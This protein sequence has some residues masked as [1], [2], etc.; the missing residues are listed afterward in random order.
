MFSIRKVV[1]TV[2]TSSHRRPLRS[3]ETASCHSQCGTFRSPTVLQI[4]E[5]SYQLLTPTC[6]AA[7]AERRT[8]E[9]RHGWA[10]RL[11]P[12][13]LTKH[14]PEIKSDIRAHTVTNELL[15]RPGNSSSEAGSPTTVLGITATRPSRSLPSWMCQEEPACDG[16]GH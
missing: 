1:I 4:C 16:H 15:D 5:L 8:V 6:L 2:K 3:F 7:Q 9:W 13:S 10:Y 14:P 11:G 12:T